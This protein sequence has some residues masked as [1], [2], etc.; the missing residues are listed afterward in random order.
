[1]IRL[2]LNWFSFVGGFSFKCTEDIYIL[3]KRTRHVASLHIIFYLSLLTLNAQDTIKS[4]NLNEISIID[5]S[6]HNDFS[7]KQ[8]GSL[9]NKGT[10]E[11]IESSSVGDIAKFVAGV[12]LKDYG[13]IGGLKTISVRGLGSQN[14]AV[15]YDGVSVSD[16]AS[17]QIDLSKFSTNNIS[18]VNLANG[19]KFSL[20]QPA[21]ALASANVFFI[22]TQK[23]EFDSLENIK[24]AIKSTYGSFN[25][26]NF[27]LNT[28]IKVNKVW[29][30][31][32]DLD[33][34]NTLG[35]Y[36]YTL[37]YGNNENDSTSKE[38]RKNSDYFAFR[39]EWNA[40]AAWRNKSDLK[41]KAYYFYSDR[42]L[43]GSTTLYYQNSKQRLWDESFFLQGVFTHHF[44]NKLSYRNHSKANYSM[45]HYLDPN[46]FNI[47][48][49][50]D[51]KYFQKEYYTNNV[52]M[53]RLGKN[54][55]TSIT[56][57]L[58]YNT[59][60]SSQA[61]NAMPKRFTSLSGLVA[62]Y[63]NTKFELNANLLH[64]FSS[65]NS[66][67]N[68]SPIFNNHFSPFLSIGYTF[69]ETLTISAFYKDVFRMPTFND[70]YFNIISPPTLRPEKAEQFNLHIAFAKDF[71]IYHST[72]LNISID[73]YH[74]NV[75]DKLVAIP[76]KNLFI[77]SMINFGK[78]EI[79]GL[80]LQSSIR[81]Y[82]PYS[83]DVTLRGT[84]SLQMA[85]DKSDILST[86]YNNQ[87]PY[88]PLHSGS[89][90]LSIIHPFA[91][92]SYSV[93]FVGDRY[94]LI[95]NIERNRLK[96][97]QDHTIMVSKTFELKKHRLNIGLSCLNLL[98]KQYEVVRYYPMP[99]RQFRIN[100]KMNLK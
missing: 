2:F 36:P 95:E 21:R 35:N 47:S 5:S 55:S 79:N 59:M 25:Y 26:L 45:V 75:R 73:A 30:S 12:T 32:L 61:F 28:A 78:I 42:G 51:D 91:E 31:C 24:L 10:I 62:S 74:N 46:V 71:G 100:L 85:R 60:T 19:Q 50:Q 89:L 99:L 92:L 84:Y 56:N 94:V 1:M 23:P 77:W 90:L 29:T 9:L 3:F 70:L 69:K 33:I 38:R 27:G 43:P 88:T 54:F 80:D 7:A 14:T 8:S 16:Q 96:P 37:S 82:L 44:S 39:G 22:E 57:D 18:Q 93:T 41:L 98:G 86:K 67:F 11:K 58:V 6:I 72:F 87:I 17:G 65:D 15:I 68:S 53:Y 20:L 34:T 40:F 97:Y 49:K 76:N 81:F 66:I 4:V 64:T 63:N 48:G 13:G 52:V 83:L